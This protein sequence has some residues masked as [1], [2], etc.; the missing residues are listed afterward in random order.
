MQTLTE[1]GLVTLMTEVEGILNFRPLVP[2][3]LHDSEEDL[4][5]P[6]HLL[7]LKSNPNLPPGTLD[8]NSCR[9]WAQVQFLGQ[10]IFSQSFAAAK[11]IQSRKKFRSRG[12]SIVS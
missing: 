11:M 3:M 12:G 9:R 10:R 5:T 7:L 2:L 6:K 4:L 1:E 8:T